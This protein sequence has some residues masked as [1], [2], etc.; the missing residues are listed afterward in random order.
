MKR[1]LDMKRWMMIA[2]ALLLALALGAGLWFVRGMS[3]LDADEMQTEAGKDAVTAYGQLDEDGTLK[4]EQTFYLTNRTGAALEE[5]V[6]RLYANASA[7]SAVKSLEASINGDPVGAKIDEDDATLVTIARPWAKDEA[8]DLTL[9][10]KIQADVD[11]GIAVVALPVLASFREGRWQ[12]EP[13]DPLAGTLYAPAMDGELDVRYPK[14]WKA[15][16]ANGTRGLTRAVSQNACVRWREIGGVAVSAMADNVFAANRL[17]DYAKTALES[18]EAI[19]LAY[20]FASLAVV[21]AQPVSADGDVYS[22]MIVLN[23]EGK[24]EELIRRMTRLIAA[25]TFG[26]LVG[27]DAWNAPWLSRSLSSAAELIAYRQRKGQA[28]F[29]SRYE[30]EIEVASRVT[31]PFGVT[32]GADIWRFGGDMEMTRVLR[33]QG[34]AMLLGIEQA[35]GEAAFMAALQL[36]IEENAG[37]FAGR[38]ALERALEAVSGS[39]WSGYLEDELAY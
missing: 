3:P 24:K 26:A 5:I 13:F 9:W 29:E 4:I 33:D 22:S 28:A 14:G 38:A 6:L 7:S 34:G 8:I 17:L 35:I 31:R 2:A 12:K 15:V 30:A 37:G 19:G 18:L 36:Y 11:E 39:S 20:P 32:V 25:Q 23:P 10:T 21:G 16:F 27:S 1:G